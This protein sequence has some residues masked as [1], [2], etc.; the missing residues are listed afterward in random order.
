MITENS[1]TILLSAEV[2]LAKW[3]PQGRSV[4]RE[5]NCDD[6]S[7][8]TTVSSLDEVLMIELSIDATVH[9]SMPQWLLLGQSIICLN[10]VCYSML[11]WTPFNTNSWGPSKLV[12]INSSL[13]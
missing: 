1:K 5:Q 10:V 11:Q 3:S 2:A 4:C 9:N 13:Y 6:V 8:A 7:S 12:L